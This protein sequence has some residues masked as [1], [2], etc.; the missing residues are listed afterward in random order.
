MIGDGLGPTFIPLQCGVLKKCRCDP[1]RPEEGGEETSDKGMLLPKCGGTH[2]VT[3]MWLL[4]WQNRQYNLTTSLIKT[5]TNW[6]KG[7]KEINYIMELLLPNLS[8]SWWDFHAWLNC[9]QRTPCNGSFLW[10]LLSNEQERKPLS[11]HRTP[12]RR[13][14]RPVTRHI[15]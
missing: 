4:C 11:L 1:G 10:S 6:H 12:G 13:C 9:L 15:S 5:S 14:I 7:L 2:V 3:R 8:L